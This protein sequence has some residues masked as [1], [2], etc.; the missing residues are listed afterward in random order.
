MHGT[1]THTYTTR[2]AVRTESIIYTHAHDVV[3]SGVVVMTNP[4]DIII[5]KHICSYVF[6]C[7]KDIEFSILDC[8][9][10]KKGDTL[11]SLL[12][13]HRVRE[14]LSLYINPQACK[15]RP[16]PSPFQS[17]TTTTKSEA[18]TSS[19]YNTNNISV[20]SNNNNNNNNINNNNNSNNNVITKN[21]TSRPIAPTPLRSRTGKRSGLSFA[22]VLFFRKLLCL[23]ADRLDFLCGQTQLA[24]PTKLVELV[25]YCIIVV[26][27][28]V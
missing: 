26:V 18:T 3:N 13:R 5:I 12:C 7:K 27:E 20:N 11:Q 16:R 19:S 23:A 15:E 1:N 14:H 4:F 17:A 22:L 2:L 10:W 24:I 25:C 8:L 9:A 21:G 6:L 28:Y